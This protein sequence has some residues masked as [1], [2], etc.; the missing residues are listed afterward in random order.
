MTALPYPT[1]AYLSAPDMVR[2][3]QR[4]GLSVCIAGIAAR[5]EQDFLRWHDF[6]TSAR[7]AGHSAQGVI[8]LMPIADCRL[9]MRSASPSSMSTA[10]RGTPAPAC[11]R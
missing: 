1:T 3:V 8:E 4:K 7:V 11:P 5:I 2:L 10:T 9:P 6:D